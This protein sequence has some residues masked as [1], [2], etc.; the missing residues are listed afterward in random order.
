MLKRLLIKNFTVFTDADFQFGPGLNVV[1]GT[2]GT[3][4]SHVLK[5]GYAMEAVREMTKRSK[6][7]GSERYAES[8]GGWG[9]ILYRYLPNVFL[10][11]RMGNLIRNTVPKQNAVVQAS[12]KFTSMH[13]ESIGFELDSEGD[14][15]RIIGSTILMGGTVSAPV[16]IPAKEV[17]SIFPGL[18]SLNKKYLLRFDQTYTD[19]LDALEL[20]PLRSLPDPTKNLLEGTL[21]PLMQGQIVLENGG[22]YLVSKDGSRLEIN[23]VAEGVRKFG[24]L[25]Q[26]LNN[27]SLT[28]DST[29]YWDEPEA[30]LNPALL[31][32]LAA[33]LAELAR[34]GFQIILATHSM[35]LLKEF[36]ILSRQKDAK[37]LPI[38][39]FG[40]NAQP[41]EATRIVSTDNFE[42]LPDI[43]ALSE[44]LKQADELEEIFIREDQE[45]HANNRGKE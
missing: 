43:V 2:N 37:P 4:K 36:H 11:E 7:M 35:G 24:I 5:L 41:G 15:L 27:G 10:A 19:L 33:L 42:F 14:G 1:V 20:P 17:L 25:A 29:L 18:N 26:L 44:E 16:F 13:E 28:F 9:E 21:Q 31:R 8:H 23:L 12:F 39:Y 45:Y 38:K 32:K 40:L 3:G 22:F 34:R 6:P 30:N